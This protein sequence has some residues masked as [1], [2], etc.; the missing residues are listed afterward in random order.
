M[1]KSIRKKESRKEEF[2][3]EDIFISFLINVI[4]E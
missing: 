1:Y 2:A 3:A 4:E